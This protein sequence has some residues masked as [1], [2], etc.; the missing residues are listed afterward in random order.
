M[1][2]TFFSH[3][4]P[5]A[6]MWLSQPILDLFIFFF[7]FYIKKGLIGM[8]CKIKIQFLALL[9]LNIYITE[10]ERERK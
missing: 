8:H 4:Y 2:T 9:V 7:L 5:K 3:N 10:R 6:L 1:Y